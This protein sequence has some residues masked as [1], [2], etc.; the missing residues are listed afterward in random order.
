MELFTLLG[1]LIDESALGGFNFSQ[2]NFIEDEQYNGEEPFNDLPIAIHLTAT[3]ERQEY[4]ESLLENGDYVN[5]ESYKDIAVIFKNK[6]ISK[7]QFD[8]EEHNV[9]EVIE[10]YVTDWNLSEVYTVICEK[11][12]KQLLREE[13]Y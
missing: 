3:P 9:K 10:R 6:R 2:W 11:I 1:I 5:A 7:I 4:A 12:F 8:D 13:I